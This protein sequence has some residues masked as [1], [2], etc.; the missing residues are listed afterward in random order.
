MN[1]IKSPVT[2]DIKEIERWQTEVCKLLN[3]KEAAAQSDSTAAD[4]ATLKADFNSLL[5]KLRTAKLLD[6]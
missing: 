5:A 3:D 4:V 1:R 2:R 6:T